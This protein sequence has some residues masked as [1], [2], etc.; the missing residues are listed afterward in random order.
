MNIKKTTLCISAFIVVSILITYVGFF[1]LN[2]SVQELGGV[3]KQRNALLLLG[4]R[5]PAKLA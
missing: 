5:T 1:I 4:G 2:S 3:Q